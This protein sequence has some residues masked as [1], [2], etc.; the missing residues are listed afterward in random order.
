MEY[1]AFETSTH[2]VEQAGF[3]EPQLR[4][5]WELVAIHS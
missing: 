3:G 4:H 1:A 2:R 5:G